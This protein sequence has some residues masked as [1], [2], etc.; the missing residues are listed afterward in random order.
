MDVSSCVLSQQFSGMQSADQQAPYNL[1]VNISLFVHKG[2][3][4]C[5]EL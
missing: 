1:G 5:L 3:D 2:A 4:F